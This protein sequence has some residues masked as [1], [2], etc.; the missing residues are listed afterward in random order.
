MIRKKDFIDR[1]PDLDPD[2]SLDFPDFLLIAE[3]GWNFKGL[4]SNNRMLYHIEKYNPTLPVYST[5]GSTGHIEEI[6][7]LM[8]KALAQGRKVLLAVVEGLDEADFFLPHQNV[9][10]CRDWYAYAGYNLYHTLVTGKPFSQCTHPPIYNMSARR[11]L[12]LRYPLSTPHIGKICEDSIGRRAGVRTAA[13][14]SRSITT[15]AM[16]NADLM[17]ECYI[18]SQAN[19][20]VLVA[21]NEDRY[22]LD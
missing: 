19:M 9:D 21:V 12:P 2:Y 11:A 7:G 13:V 4:C 16:V 10:N 3:D 18:R 8:E 1:Y 15:H 14:G 5:I 22:Q 20:G 6:C 17:L